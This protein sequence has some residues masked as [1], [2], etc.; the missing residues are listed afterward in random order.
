MTLQEFHEYLNTQVIEDKIVYMRYKYSCE[1]EWTY[2]NEI[3]EVDMDV[4]GYY[5]WN[6]DWNEGQEEVE[7]LGCIAISDIDV[8]EFETLRESTKEQEPFTPTEDDY[9]DKC[10][11]CPWLDRT[12]DED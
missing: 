11:T 1:D 7:I 6:S 10:A 8:P 12:F 5:I 2:A 9:E 3:L 4:D